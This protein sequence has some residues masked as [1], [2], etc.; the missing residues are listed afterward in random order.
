MHEH[1]LIQLSIGLAGLALW[2]AETLWGGR[3]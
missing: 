2:L 1:N 3:Q